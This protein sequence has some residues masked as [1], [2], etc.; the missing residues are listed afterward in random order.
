MVCHETY[1]DQNNKW[2]SPEEIEKNDK[3]FIK[4]SDKTKVMLVLRV[5]VKIKKKCIDPEI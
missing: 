2:L 3:E 4:I 1:K 5:N